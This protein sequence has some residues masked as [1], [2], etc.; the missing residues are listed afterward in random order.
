M[1]GG[2]LRMSMR[3]PPPPPHG[4]GEAGTRFEVLRLASALASAGTRAESPESLQV[5]APRLFI[6]SF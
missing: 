6:Y 1:G 2:E 5:S 4:G 3:S